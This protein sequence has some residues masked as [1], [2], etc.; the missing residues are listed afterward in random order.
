MG[1]IMMTRRGF[2][3]TILGATAVA[4]AVPETIEPIHSASSAVPSGRASASSAAATSG[5]R[6]FDIIERLQANACAEIMAE[7]DARFLE[8]IA[9]RH[10]R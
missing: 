4:A 3:A 6:R 10:P 1:D 9:G 2:L 5:D 8:A 7:E